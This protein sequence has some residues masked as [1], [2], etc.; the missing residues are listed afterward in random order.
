MRRKLNEMNG[1]LRKLR[2][3][4]LFQKLYKHLCRVLQGYYNYYGFAGNY[5]T[6]NKFRYAIEN[7]WFK[8]LNRRSQRKSFNWQ[9]Y[10]RLLK[11][12]PLPTPRIHK[13][14]SWIYA[15]EIL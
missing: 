6:L 2:N 14:Y 12:Y 4:M 5:A 9:E 1:K 11:L 7:M 15:S 10:Q 3:A 13:G 8:W